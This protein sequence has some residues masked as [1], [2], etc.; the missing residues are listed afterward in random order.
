MLHRQDVFTTTSNGGRILRIATPSSSRIRNVFGS[1]SI[2]TVATETNIKGRRPEKK[3]QRFCHH[4]CTCYCVQ[5]DA[6]ANNHE[7]ML[8][9]T[10]DSYSYSLGGERIGSNSNNFQR[11]LHSISIPYTNNTT[12]TNEEN[13]QRCIDEYFMGLALEEAKEA[14]HS[15]DEV[16][17]GAIVVIPAD[18]NNN[19]KNN[20]NSNNHDSSPGISKDHEP[21]SD[22]QKCLVKHFE[23]LSTGQNQIET[24][25]DASAHAEMQ[26]L[27]SASRTIQ[28]WRLLN[29]T[30][31]TTLEPC[32]MCLSAAQ[33]FRVSRIVYGAPDLRLGAVETFMKLLDYP[34]PFHGS[35]AMEVVGGVR[36][37][38]ARMLLVDFFRQRRKKE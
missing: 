31:Y 7:N 3:R 36:S 17:I 37:D 24:Q 8:L 21:F 15:H 1:P 34:H 10:T 27:R 19:I 35:G 6:V 2:N 9:D 32:P 29:A 28:N 11:R 22:Q 16:P 20:N 38:E 30:L 25:Y 12:T 4:F 14:G 5:E 23:I 26:A 33:A 13:V 18:N